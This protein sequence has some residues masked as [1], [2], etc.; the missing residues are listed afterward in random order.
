M[1]LVD[2][3]NDEHMTVKGM[4]YWGIFLAAIIAMIA[5]AKPIP[6]DPPWHGGW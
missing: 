2:K 1:L 6:G 3:Y 5:T 4:L